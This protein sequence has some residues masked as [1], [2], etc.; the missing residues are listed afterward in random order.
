MREIYLKAPAGW[1][2]ISAE[3]FLF[4][5]KLFEEQLSESEFLTR[6]LID[7]T[8]IDPV[9]HRIEVNDG[10]LLFEFLDPEGK[11]FSLSA[12]QMKSLTDELRW[13]LDSVG[14]C[15]L[16]ERLGGLFPVDS[17]LFGITLEE[18]LLADQLYASYS[19]NKRID[20]LNRFVAVFYRKKGDKWDERDYK[21]YVNIIRSVPNHAK[22][23]VY[24]WF[25]GLK[26]WIMDKYP[27]MFGDP[28]SAGETSILSPDEHI[29]RLFSSLNDGDVTRNK[30]ILHTHVH[31]VFYELNQ[32]IENQQS[33][34]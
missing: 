11:L 4:V 33:H 17:R 28:A 30:E 6:C 21:K 22:N 1:H 9:Q 25:T 26:K 5:S 13:L 31:E 8:G 27:Y 7:F 23:A 2:D 20:D 15:R 29:L 24:L 32:K 10:E 18:Y 3:G 14:L 12:E 34:V 19:V 16:P